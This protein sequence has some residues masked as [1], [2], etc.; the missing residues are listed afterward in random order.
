MTSENNLAC[1]NVAYCGVHQAFQLAL[2]AQESGWLRRFDCSLYDAPGKWGGVARHIVGAKNLCNRRLE[3]I[4]PA[5]VFE[6]PW[7]FLKN[8]LGKHLGGESET[9]AFFEAFDGLTAR[10]I[11]QSPPKLFVGT[12]RCDLLS[13]QTAVRNDVCTIHDCPQLHPVTLDS[14]MREASDACGIHWGGFSDGESMKRRKVLEYEYAD[15]ILVYSEFHRQSFLRAGF[16]D[17]RIFQCPLWVDHSFW[18]PDRTYKKEENTSSRLRL[19]FVGEWSLRKGLPFLFRALASLPRAVTL[20]L[21]GVSSN[22][23]PIPDRVGCVKVQALGAVN[24]AKLRTLYSSHDLLVLPSIADSFGFVALEAMACGLPVLLTENCG[25]PVPDSAWRVP[26]MNSDAI[27][28]GIIGYLDQS[29]NLREAAN[30][31]IAFAANFTPKRY[32]DQI[33]LLYQEMLE[34]APKALHDIKNV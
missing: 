12:E 7:P 15:K 19:L 11:E 16:D 32:R 27:A 9:M 3:G 8:W 17:K 2:A 34:G 18:Q 33:R 14:L 1:I 6:H 25:A 23:F 28:Q 13:L 26:G 22:E 20:T 31:A 24:K 5:F 21:V 4:D 29:E 10:L 30:Q